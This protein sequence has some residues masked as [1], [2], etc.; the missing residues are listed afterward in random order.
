MYT[1]EAMAECDSLPQQEATL[2]N[3]VVMCETLHEEHA[4][5]SFKFL[6]DV[7]S[8]WSYQMRQFCI[9]QDI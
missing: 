6:K 9:K 3:V 1:T 4:K 7:I 2:F 8:S 5:E